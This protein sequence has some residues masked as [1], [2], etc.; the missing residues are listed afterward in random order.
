MAGY[1]GYTNYETWC[2]CLWLDNDQGQ[3]EHWAERYAEAMRNNDTKGEAVSELAIELEESFENEAPELSGFWAD[4]FRS[5]FDE[6]NWDEV[7]ETRG[8]E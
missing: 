5:A 3:Q 1:N 2:V 8:D 7:A 6:I 4:I